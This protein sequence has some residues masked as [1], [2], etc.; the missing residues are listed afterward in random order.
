MARQYMYSREGGY[1]RSD[2]EVACEEDDEGKNDC[3]EP[4]KKERRVVC[5]NHGEDFDPTIR[6]RC[7]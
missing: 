1:F 3:I 4:L 2:R 6:C 7:C 5:L